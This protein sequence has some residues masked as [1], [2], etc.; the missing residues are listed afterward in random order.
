M[1]P[2]TLPEPSWWVLLLGRHSPSSPGHPQS[3]M[4]SLPQGQPE[5]GEEAGLR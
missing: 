2:C 5:P 3:S 1:L 4:S